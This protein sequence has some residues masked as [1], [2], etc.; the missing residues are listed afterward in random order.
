M[1]R[2]Q[3]GFTLE[4]Q[5]PRPYSNGCVMHFISVHICWATSHWQYTRQGIRSLYA[6]VPVQV[7]RAAMGATSRHPSAS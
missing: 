2:A 6:C 4:L 7:E 5:M 1:I 3:A